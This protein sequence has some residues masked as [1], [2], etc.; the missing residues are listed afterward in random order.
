MNLMDRAQLGY[1]K[2]TNSL[3][4]LRADGE[5]P[6]VEELAVETVVL[7][8]LSGIAMDRIPLEARPAILMAARTLRR[9]FVGDMAELL[10]KGIA[11]SRCEV[12]GRA[13]EASGGVLL[14]HGP[15]PGGELSCPGTGAEVP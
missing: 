11:P 14:L 4:D 12:C 6:T 9:R 2:V 15:G 10:R 13:A 1:T 8:A 3:M 7:M 5:K